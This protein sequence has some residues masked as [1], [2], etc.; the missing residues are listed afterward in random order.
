MGSILIVD[1]EPK[2]LKYLGK[3]LQKRGLEVRTADSG[4]K[5]L[6]IV[7]TES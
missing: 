6:E 4:E 3:Y 1:D 2:V 5:G 7:K